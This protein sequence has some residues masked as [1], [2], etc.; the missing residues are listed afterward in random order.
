MLSPTQEQEQEAADLVATLHDSSS[1]SFH[2]WLT[3]AEYGQRFGLA[4][5][6]TTKI[7]QWL[8]TQGLV[9]HEIS[10]SRRFIVF[11]GTAAQVEQ[12]F[13]TEMHTYS[14]KSKKFIANSTNVQIPAS[15]SQVVK[16]VVRLH[17]NP[18]KTDLKIG[19]KFP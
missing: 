5:E 2:K 6:D 8:E 19:P 15:L 10:R 18:I 9:V 17:S 4:Q 1:P 14:Y 16:G 3:P 12:A 13:S 11:S 7:Q